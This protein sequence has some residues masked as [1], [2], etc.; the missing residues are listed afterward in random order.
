[1]ENSHKTNT[2]TSEEKVASFALLSNLFR[3][4]IRQYGMFIALFVIMIIFN[5]LTEGTFISSRNLTNLYL[6]TGYIAVLAVGMVLVIVAGHIDL[7]VGSVAAFTGAIAAI[8]QV[9]MGLPT[10]PTILLTMVVGCM[11]GMWK[12][13]GSHSRCTSFYS[14]ACINAYV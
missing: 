2:S 8:L 7:S 10:I 12:D 1:M 14:F 13:T 4:N 3:A 6:Q 11:I 9:K 5:I